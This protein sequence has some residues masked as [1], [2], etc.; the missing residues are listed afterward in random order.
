[1]KH[2]T[3]KPFPTIDSKDFERGKTRVLRMVSASDP[4]DHRCQMLEA[5]IKHI[6]HNV[7][8]METLEQAWNI[9]QSVRCNPRITMQEFAAMMPQTLHVEPEL[10]IARAQANRSGGKILAYDARAR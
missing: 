5:L 6:V 10:A 9:F 8:S 3:P 7:H 2:P 1:M 4:K